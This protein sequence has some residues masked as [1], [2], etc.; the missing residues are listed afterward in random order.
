MATLIN[1]VHYMLHI[2]S[3][4]FVPNVSEFVDKL[5]HLNEDTLNSIDFIISPKQKILCYKD[6]TFYIVGG[7]K[8]NIT[9]LNVNET[10]LYNNLDK[11]F[12]C[13]NDGSFKI[14]FKNTNENNNENTNENIN[15][16]NSIN[17]ITNHLKEKLNI[18]YITLLDPLNYYINDYGLIIL[19][20]KFL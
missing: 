8:Y 13:H 17:D 15:I 4:D 1:N 19:L 14:I 7:K 6:K 10:L 20:N 3:E 11:Y 16:L 5:K 2:S 18:D 12:N 9:N